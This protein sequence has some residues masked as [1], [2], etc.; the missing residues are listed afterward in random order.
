MESHTYFISQFFVFFRVRE[1]FT[2]PCLTCTKTIFM[3]SSQLPLTFN[4]KQVVFLML[5]F[6]KQNEYGKWDL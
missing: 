1:L 4:I 3:S 5:G 6:S 2:D